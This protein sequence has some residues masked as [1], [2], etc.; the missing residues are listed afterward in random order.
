MKSSLKIACIAA[1]F[2]GSISDGTA[3]SASEGVSN[4]AILVGTSSPL[5]GPVAATCK[6][7]TDGALAW[8]AS[9]NKQ[10][11][12]HGRKI[13]N[14]VMDDAY[15][16]PEALS[17]ARELTGKPVFVMFGGCGTI[18]PPAIMPLAQQFKIPYLFPFAGNPELMTAPYTFALLPTYGNQFQSLVLSLLKKDGGG[19]VFAVVADIPGANEV[20]DGVKSAA[21][22]GGG[23]LVGSELI[24]PTESDFTPTVLKIKASG[25][26]YVATNLNGGGSARLVR[27][28]AANDAYP[29]KYVIG[30]P[31]QASGSFIEPAGEA[32]NG[33]VIATLAQTPDSDARAKTCVDA[34]KASGGTLTTDVATLWGC[35]TAQVLTVAL[36]KI[37]PKPSR[38][39]L[40][41]ELETWK[42]FQASPLLPPITFSSK[43]RLG[44]STM[45][46]VRIENGKPIVAGQFD[47]LP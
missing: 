35:A 7:I 37:G 12:V 13:N 47:L 19:K 18:Q 20:V 15:K 6:P 25:A 39:A 3:Q 46:F 24:S 40:M 21:A 16:A 30:G 33:K 10:G 31:A 8:F 45:Y 26:D 22:K 36:E 41:K 29:K 11:G 4:D 1:S 42:D 32:A 44:L 17:N 5:T 28:M 9:V 34:I 23:Q 43:Q 14:I 27:A 2:A 38:E